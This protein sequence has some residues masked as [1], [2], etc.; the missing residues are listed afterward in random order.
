MYVCLYAFLQ[1]YVCM[2]MYDSVIENIRIKQ[3]Y[4]AMYAILTNIS[5]LEN[6]ELYL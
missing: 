2:H 1:N 3:S 5:T 6:S 4:H